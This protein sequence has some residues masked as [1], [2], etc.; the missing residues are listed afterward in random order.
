MKKTWIILLIVSLLITSCSKVMPDLTNESHDSFEDKAVLDEII[1]DETEETYMMS[2]TKP[3]ETENTQKHTESVSIGGH[4]PCVHSVMFNDLEI[5]FTYHSL[6]PFISYVGQDSFREWCS[7]AEPQKKAAFERGEAS[8]P[9]TTVV[10]LVEYFDIPQEDFT[11]L[12]LNAPEY[13]DYNVDVIYAGTDVAEEYYTRERTQDAAARQVLHCMKLELTQ[14]VIDNKPEAYN[15][16]VKEKNADGWFGSELFKNNLTKLTDIN[17]NISNILTASTEFKGT[18]IS[19]FSIAEMISAFNIPREVVDM[20]YL[21][22]KK[23]AGFEGTID[24]DTLFTANMDTSC[25]KTLNPIDID[26]QYFTYT[27]SIVEIK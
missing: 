24:I 5:D 27:E 18:N 10:E 22:N 17:K 25:F 13:I 2:E 26:M 11:L 14:Y 8:C 23:F 21:N 3:V 9:Y 6:G 15:A 12:I 20:A 7:I 19:Q 4:T 16:W 1:L